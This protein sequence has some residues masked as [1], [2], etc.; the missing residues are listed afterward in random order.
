MAAVWPEI[1]ATSTG[2]GSTKLCP[3]GQRWD[4]NEGTCVPIGTRPGPAPKP[5]M[6]SGLPAPYG[7][8][9]P[10]QNGPMPCPPGQTWK[11]GA[12]KGSGS[13]VSEGGATASGGRG[14]AWSGGSGSASFAPSGL[15]ANALDWERLV[16]D[17][18]KRLLAQ[19]TRYTPEVMQSLFG[20]VTRGTANAIESGERAVRADAARRGMQRAGS[21]GAALRD[22]RS[23]A[24]AARGAQVVSIMQEKIKADYTDKLA[25]LERAQQYLNSLRDSEYRFMLASEQR[26][27]FD[28]NLTLAYAN[29][30]QQWDMLNTQMGYQLLMVGV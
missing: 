5:G 6:D 10:M 25:A 7:A 30:Q 28:A 12:T 21:T 29:M 17:Y 13:C 3:A 20:Q 19:G 14:G 16:G 9:L 15:S 27:Q 1:F 24:E 2:T 8:I 4:A 11:P 26:R 18:V 22:V 23:N